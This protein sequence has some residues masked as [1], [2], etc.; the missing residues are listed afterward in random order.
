MDSHEYKQAKYQFSS[1]ENLEVFKS[2]PEKYR[3]QLGGWCA[4][5]MIEGVSINPKSFKVI[6]GKL[7]LFYDGVWGDTLKR[8]NKLLKDQAESDLVSKV[9]KEWDSLK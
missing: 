8:W 9:H 3:P 5:A 6:D 1:K 4:F 2:N 7:Y